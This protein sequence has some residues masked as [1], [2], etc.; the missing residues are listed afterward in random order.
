[1][2]K[3]R[4]IVGV[5][6]TEEEAI[7]AIEG[8][9]RQGYASDDISIISKNR[10]DLHGVMNETGT[11]APQGATAGAATGGIVGGATGLLASLGLLAIPGI[12]PI[13]AAG[14]IAATL[15]GLAVGAGT[16]GI[17]GG[18]IGMGIPEDEA[19]EYEAYVRD[20]RI[21]VLVDSRAAHDTDYD[22]RANLDRDVHDTFRENRSLN[23]NYYDRV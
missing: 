12:G 4:K 23:A 10:D 6:T 21:L 16:G 13:L 1:M 19:K 9:K 11:K 3:H 22:A 2:A 17:V 15:T 20:G 18:L 14:P 7:S 8:L 5:F